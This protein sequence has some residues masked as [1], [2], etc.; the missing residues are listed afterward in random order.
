FAASGAL[1]NPPA[2]ERCDPNNGMTRLPLP[3]T[4]PVREPI[5]PCNPTKF[6]EGCDRGQSP[7]LA[8][9]GVD[10]LVLPA[11]LRARLRV[12]PLGHQLAAD[13]AGI[14]GRGVDSADVA[15]GV[16]RAG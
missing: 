13:E 6:A 14:A 7:A 9:A 12:L 1:H 10:R 4:K 15:C 16:G 5:L 2:T 3:L 8:P 11:A